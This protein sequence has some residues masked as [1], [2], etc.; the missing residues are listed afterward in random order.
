MALYPL[1][2]PKFFK[3]DGT[4]AS[5]YQLFFYETGTT[6]KQ[7]TFDGDGG[8]TNP[9]PIIL[10]SRGEPDNA[11]TPI[12]IFL[13]DGLVYKVVFTT[14]TDTDPP[15]S[16]I[17]T[18]DG[19]TSGNV[20]LGSGTVS[21]W[22]NPL[23][24][25]RTTTTSFTI[26]AM[27]VSSLFN[28]YRR[29]YASGG[30][31]QRYATVLTAVYGG[32]DT[33][34]TV[35]D[36]IDENGNAATLH[37]AMDTV[38]GLI[39]DVC[40]AC[41]LN[42]IIGLLKSYTTTGDGSANG[43][44]FNI[45]QDRID[46][47]EAN[48]G[49]PIT[50]WSGTTGRI[51]AIGLITPSSS[52]AGNDLFDFGTEG[53]EL[54]Q[55]SYP[56]T[57]VTIS[58]DA[59]EGNYL[60]LFDDAIGYAYGTKSF[61]L[62]P[63]NYYKFRVRAKHDGAGTLAGFKFSLFY[64]KLFAEPITSANRD[65]EYIIINNITPTLTASWATYDYTVLIPTGAF[66]G[67]AVIG[68]LTDTNQDFQIAWIE[69]NPYPAS[70]FRGVLVYRTADVS[71][72]NNTETLIAFDNESY[73]TDA[74]MHDN[75]TNNSRLVVPSGVTWVRVHAQVAW[76][77]SGLTGERAAKIY[78][79]GSTVYTGAA[80][81]AM[82]HGT[83]G[84]GEFT[85]SYMSTPPLLVSPGTYFEMKVYQNIGAPLNLR[86]GNAQPGTWFALEVLER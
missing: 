59:T 39:I 75:V 4:F 57:P 44:G 37:V 65:G 11:G 81:T 85:T 30:G 68:N 7:D 72:A 19:V 54:A 6:T 62:I 18:V 3:N 73:K 41:E 64:K 67:S 42:A 49:V 25:T 71:I 80:Y 61:R 66:W 45:K 15:T 1:V 28:K 43:A 77:P 34:V 79:N 46:A 35:T 13:T 33:V 26:A 20:G 51:D 29:I 83:M 47:Y 31:F 63:G 14:D 60:N 69:V 17:W 84:S 78:A 21:M 12:D 86:H 53:W 22:V 24:A 27:D 16:P 8:A 52:L 70:S 58:N 74:T 9:N 55:G 32:V 50:T 10:N 38:Y 82:P 2:R 5:G 40:P 23:T 48:N 36:T 56:S 76:D